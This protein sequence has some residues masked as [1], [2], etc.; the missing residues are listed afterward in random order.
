MDEIIEFINGCQHVLNL[1]ECFILSEEKLMSSKTLMHI[2]KEILICDL[3][4]GD[5]FAVLEIIK[6]WISEGKIEIDAQDAP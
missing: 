2:I 4:D 6:R 3:N 1:P 5:R